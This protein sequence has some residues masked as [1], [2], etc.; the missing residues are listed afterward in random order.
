MR[1]GKRYGLFPLLPL[2]ADWHAAEVGQGKAG[3][4]PGQ[5]THQHGGHTTGELVAIQFQPLK[6]LE[7]TEFAGEVPAQLVVAYVQVHEA[8]Q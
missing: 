5:P 3:P 8:V 1:S 6:V 2:P 7:A 4:V